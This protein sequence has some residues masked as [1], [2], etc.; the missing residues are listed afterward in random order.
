MSMVQML[1]LRSLIARFWQ[2]PYRRK[3]V[4]WGTELHDRFMLP[5]FVWNDFTDVIDDLN[6]AGYPF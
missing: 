4:H 6:R 2:Q 1:L 5:W 3:P